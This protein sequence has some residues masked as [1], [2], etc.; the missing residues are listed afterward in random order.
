M[1]L[2]PDQYVVEYY[3]EEY[4]E[5]STADEKFVVWAIQDV[6]TKFWNAYCKMPFR[7]ETVR[8]IGC[9]EKINAKDALA[10]VITV[11]RALNDLSL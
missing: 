10:L 11:A 4:V 2:S 6:Q 8:L 1:N 3:V 9:F 5:V 7:P